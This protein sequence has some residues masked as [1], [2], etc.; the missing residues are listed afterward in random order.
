MPEIVKNA[1]KSWKTTLF[2]I[3]AASFPLYQ[4]AVN[5]AAANQPIDWKDFGLGAGLLALGFLAKDGD[6]TGTTQTDKQ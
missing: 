3:I 1:K 5:T 6:V 2:G 4:A